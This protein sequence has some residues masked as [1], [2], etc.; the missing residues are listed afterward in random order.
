[1]LYSDGVLHYSSDVLAFDKVEA[2][3]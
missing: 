2:L 3:Q 1:V